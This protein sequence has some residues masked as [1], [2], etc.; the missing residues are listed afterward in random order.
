MKVNCDEF[1]EVY[2]YKLM[3]II[4]KSKKKDGSDYSNGTKEN[5]MFI[6]A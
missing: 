6:I 5:W 3:T 4:E 2:K 1:I